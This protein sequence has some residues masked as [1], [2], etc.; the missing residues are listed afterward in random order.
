[1]QITAINTW[2]S[3]AAGGGHSL[4]IRQNGTLWAWGSNSNGQ[5]GNGNF[6]TLTTPVQIGTVT[7]WSSIS[8]GTTFSMGLR[9]DGSLWTWGVNTDGQLGLGDT[10]TRSSP[11]RVGTANDWVAIHASEGNSLALKAD[12]TLWVAGR[13]TSGQINNSNSANAVSFVRV[14][15]HN[16]WSK[17]GSGLGTQMLAATSDGSLWGWGNNADHQVGIAARPSAL[18]E[19]AHP[20]ISA[21]TVA[22]PAVNVPAHNT[23]VTLAATASSGLPVT[24]HASGPASLVGNQLTVTGPGARVMASQNGIRPVWHTAQPVQLTFTGPPQL[25]VRENSAP[26]L[27]NDGSSYDFGGVVTG[28]PLTRT[29]KIVNGGYST[30]SLS[31]VTATGGWTVNT[32]GMITSLSAGAETTFTASITP[33]SN[34]PLSGSISIASNDVETPIHTFQVTASGVNGQSIVFDPIP[35]QT[36]GIPLTLIATATSGLPVSYVITA[37]SQIASLEGNTVNFSAAGSVTIEMRQAG[38]ATTA[39]ALTITNTFT[40]IKGTQVLSFVS[41][42][43]TSMSYRSVL[44]LSA[45]SDRGLTPI[46]FT[47]VTGP[48]L[49]SGNALVPTGQGP[50][51]VRASQAGNGAFNTATVLATITSTNFSPSSATQNFS[52]NEDASLSTMLNASDLDPGDPLTYALVAGPLHGTL[53]LSGNGSFTYEPAENFHGTDS[54]TFTAT[55]SLLASS[56]IVTASITVNPVND[57]VVPLAASFKG[58]QDDLL[59]GT[60]DA[61]DLENDPLTF[62]LSNA[63]AHGTAT[64]SASGDFRYQP[65]AG[66][67]GVDTFEFSVTDAGSTVTALVTLVISSAQPNWTWKGGPNLPNQLSIYTGLTARPGA[68]TDMA[69]WTDADGDRWLFGGIGYAAAGKAGALND[70]WK[71]SADTQTWTH[72]S[73]DTI[74]NSPGN[75]GTLGVAHAD[76]K[77]GARSGTVAW[78]G[79]DGRLWLF[80]GLGLDGTAR[81][82]PLNDLWVFDPNTTLWTWVSGSDTALSNGS[83]ATPRSPST[84][85][86]P[87]GRSGAA[88]WTSADGRLWLFGGKGF[89]SAGTAQLNLAD[90]WCYDP[91]AGTWTLLGDQPAGPSA[92]MDATAWTTPDGRFY[93]WGGRGKSYLNDLWSFDPKTTVWTSIA[94]LQPPEA[95]AGAAGWV[96][97]DGTLLLFGGQTAKGHKNNVMAYTPTA[98][99]QPAT[100]RTIKGSSALN[101]AGVYGTQNVPAPGNTPGARRKSAVF[102]DKKDNDVLAFGGG[103][104]SKLNSDLW[105]LDLP[106]LP[107]ISGLEALVVGAEIEFRASVNTLGLPG[108]VTFEVPGSTP[109]S[110]LASDNPQLIVSRVPLSSHPAGLDWSVRATTAQGTSLSAVQKLVIGPGLSPSIITWVAPASISERGGK[111]RIELHLDAPAVDTVPFTLTPSGTATEGADYT[112][113]LPSEFLP[114][115][116]IVYVEVTPIADSTS[117]GTETITLALSGLPLGINPSPASISMD[118]D[119]ATGPPSFV[120]EQASLIRHVGT[121]TSLAPQVTGA[122]SF[123]WR[124]NGKTIPGATAAS[125]TITGTPLSSVGTYQLI[126]SNSA[127]STPSQLIHLAVVDGKNSITSLAPGGSATLKALFASPVTLDFQWTLTQGAGGTNNVPSATN[128]TLALSNVTPA[129]AGIYRC[130]L[131]IPSTMATSVTGD[132]TIEV[133]TFAP[134]LSVLTALPRGAVGA[135]YGV[136]IAFNTDPL[137]APS[138]FTASGLPAGLTISPWGRIQGVPTAAVTNKVITIT[139]RNSKG[140]SNVLQP[141]LT[142]LPLPSAV[143]GRFVGA[144]ERHSSNQSGGGLL[145]FTIAGNGAFSAKYRGGKITGNVAVSL[146]DRGPSPLIAVEITHSVLTGVFNTVAN[147]FVGTVNG[148]ATRAFKLVWSPRSNRASQYT[149]YYTALADIPPALE[150][151]FETPQ[152]TSY[153]TTTATD[154]GT[155]NLVFSLADGQ[156]ATASSIIGAAGQLP[157]FASIGKT[158]GTLLGEGLITAS[159]PIN[160]VSGSVTWNKPTASAKSK[161]RAYRSG[162]QPVILTLAGGKYSPPVAGGV[163]MGLPNQNNNA[164]LSYY[165]PSLSS[166]EAPPH[167]ISIRNNKPTGTT[168]TLTLPAGL[169]FKLNTAK[170]TYEGSFTI[171]NAV[172]TLTRTYKYKGVSVRTALEWKA[173]GWS[174]FPALPQ[175]GQTLSTS[176]L[177]SGQVTLEPAGP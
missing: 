89:G 54:F 109:L 102:Q 48:A 160:P 115:Q 36:C 127:G 161:D 9:T 28:T 175:P 139:A 138:S 84:T 77:P 27:I 56:G 149:G 173:G 156:S 3:V 46:T 140:N 130:Q 147:T 94:A 40:V 114:G 90:L 57:P 118:I 35:Q 37:G 92:R 124:K 154:G 158:G 107:V 83:P 171:P 19:P 97:A 22:F 45:S 165:A 122:T 8:A 98:D 151:D 61:E 53:S 123:A 78:T 106:P 2:K 49:L 137:M 4:A 87:S 172:P 47:V 14:G 105:E 129:Q 33:P 143:L 5:L 72:V 144:A 65:N 163:I 80:G 13:N 128:S 82:G 41:N 133:V 25:Y 120:M 12:G 71:Q 11:T 136:D 42:T 169:T 121:D 141:T 177:L 63:P 60:L 74:T 62:A 32:T 15:T 153:F 70:L 10:T 64:V 162:F 55:D 73:G 174:T 110:L 58:Q 116:S 66:F 117:E 21:Q 164:R 145:D 91:D 132:F 20:P 131:T 1:V 159:A 126:A 170:G 166:A 150:G 152:G 24:Y 108:T 68:R 79:S 167:L 85:A 51:V 103:N 29:F 7:I 26:D 50:V 99:Y 176:D 135:P 38:D 16:L 76:N 148:A 113:S 43:P 93:L 104:G 134:Q 146:D 88:A 101:G 168:N 6:T 157:L 119:E 69:A 100:W 155:L 81:S 125:L 17:L 30:L 142:I 34:G 111:H 18:F 39:P 86:F 67:Q 75:Y 112:M 44:G 23:P 96:Q 52:V 59:T 31:S 95:A